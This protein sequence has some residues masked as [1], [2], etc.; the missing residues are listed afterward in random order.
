[1]LHVFVDGAGG[2]EQPLERA[3]ARDAQLL[4]RKTYEGFAAAWP[5]MEGTGPTAGR[6]GGGARAKFL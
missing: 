3:A 6:P 2:D 1:V 5:T 4:G